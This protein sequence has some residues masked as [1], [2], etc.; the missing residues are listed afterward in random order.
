MV[1]G[2]FQKN[3]R[4]NVKYS[5]M[6]QFKV[7]F[8]HCAFSRPKTCEARYHFS[9]GENASSFQTSF[10]ALHGSPNF[11]SFFQK[12]NDFCFR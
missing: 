5:K 7:I 3:W 1:F 9:A 2:C 10:D 6:R 12:K 8:K 4:E 11:S